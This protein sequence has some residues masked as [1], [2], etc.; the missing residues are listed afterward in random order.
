MAAGGANTL[1]CVADADID[2]LM[3]RTAR[4]PLARAAVPT[5][6]PRWCSGWP[7]SVVSYLLAVVDHQSALGALLAIGTVAF[8]VFVYTLLLASAEPPKTSCGGGR[9]AVCR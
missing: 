1:N 3:K 6:N 2:K 8:Y 4:R 5:R 7:S 9:P